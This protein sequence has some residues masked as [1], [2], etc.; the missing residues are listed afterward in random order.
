VASVDG[1]RDL[2]R[3]AAGRQRIDYI[4]PD[5]MLMAAPVQAQGVF[6]PRVPVA[7]FQTLIVGDGL[8]NAIGVQYDVTRDGGFLI[9]TV[10]DDVAAS[11]ITLLQN[12]RPPAK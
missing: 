1:G 3:L 8:D 9:N 12:W 5:G 2:S 11:S 10:A 6:E 7:L 4:A